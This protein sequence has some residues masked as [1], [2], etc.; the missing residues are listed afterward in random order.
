MR[1]GGV[2]YTADAAGDENRIRY[3]AG[4][5]LALAER[6]PPEPDADQLKAI[7]RELVQLHVDNPG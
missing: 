3:L 5:G 4:R 1:P 2:L 7:L 6:L